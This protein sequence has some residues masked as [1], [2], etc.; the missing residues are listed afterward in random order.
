MA[1]K[2]YTRMAKM[3]ETL[4]LPSKLIIQILL[5][6]PVKSLLCF[7]CVCKS[8]FSLISDPSHV[9]VSAARIVSISKPRPLAEIRSIDFETSINHDIVSLDHTCLLRED[10]F[11]M[12]LK[13]HAEGL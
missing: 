12:K 2:K 13:F 1:E 6:L 7:K 5:R 9:D 8:W 11:F 10:N 3:K 4:Y